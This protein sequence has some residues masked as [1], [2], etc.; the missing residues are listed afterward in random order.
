M[1]RTKLRGGYMPA[2][3]KVEPG[4][5]YNRWTII[6]EVEKKKGK[7]YFLCR[8]DC[9]TIREVRF[10]ALRSGGSKSCGCLRNDKSR[11]RRTTHGKW[12]TKIYE[13]WHHMKQR[14][15]NENDNNYDYYGGRGISV[16]EEWMDFE[17]FY[18][19]AIENGYKEGLTLERIDVNGDYCPE[20][21]TWVTQAE[22]LNNTR[23]TRKITFQGKTQ[24]LKEWWREI[25]DEINITYQSLR[26]RLN[27]GW[28]VERAFTEPKHEGFDTSD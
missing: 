26:K 13:C 11:E 1:P 20:N 6:E 5:K 24:S 22:Q 17:N 28:E 18:E 9:G 12:G 25:K 4:E 27:N 23:R 2:R 15:L 16:C 3:I 19:W 8:C 10:I 14:C 21:C 7:R